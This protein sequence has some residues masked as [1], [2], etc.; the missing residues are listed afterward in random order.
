MVDCV[1]EYSITGDCLLN[2]AIGDVVLVMT[3]LPIFVEDPLTPF[4]LRLGRNV[5]VCFI[6][7]LTL[8]LMAG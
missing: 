1:E 3:P 2:L 5:C 7:I 6:L 4:E 8:V